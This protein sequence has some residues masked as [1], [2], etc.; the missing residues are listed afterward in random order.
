M[1]LVQAFI[2]VAAV[3]VAIGVTIQ[4]VMSLRAKDETT[5]KKLWRWLKKLWHAFWLLGG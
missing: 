3:C 5:S 1:T 2:V 4:F